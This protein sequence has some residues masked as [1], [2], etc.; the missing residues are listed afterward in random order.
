MALSEGEAG[1]GPKNKVQ[2]NIEIV[3][4]RGLTMAMLVIAACAG[5][6]TALSA[7]QSDTNVLISSKSPRSILDAVRSK[8]WQGELTFDSGGRQVINLTVDKIDT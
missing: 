6:D 4:L 1:R 2:Q 7:Q 8:G 3:S 5:F